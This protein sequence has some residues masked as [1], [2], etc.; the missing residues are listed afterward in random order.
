MESFHVSIW[1]HSYVVNFLWATIFPLS[2][3]IFSIC[4]F[5]NSSY[6]YYICYKF[7]WEW[8]SGGLRWE[9]FPCAVVPK[10]FPN[11][12]YYGWWIWETRRFGTSFQF[13]L[14]TFDDLISFKNSM[15]E[16]GYDVGEASMWHTRIG[17]K[18]GF[19][20][21]IALMTAIMFGRKAWSWNQ[22]CQC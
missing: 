11:R 1:I 5:L 17:S 4:K 2:F 21:W 20:E 22:S 18:M 8:L 13:C 10:V 16:E 6:K 19:E 15:E 12:F 3:A 14:K 9:W 7:F